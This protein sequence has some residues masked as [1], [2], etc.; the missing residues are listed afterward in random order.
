MLSLRLTNTASSAPCGISTYVCSSLKLVFVDLCVKLQVLLQV[1]LA[2]LHEAYFSCST[3]FCCYICSFLDQI[4]A[5]VLNLQDSNMLE[6][7]L[8]Q[9]AVFITTRF[10]IFSKATVIS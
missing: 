2:A 5:F 1:I 3:K 6:V 8:R 4:S 9:L 7:C 10:T